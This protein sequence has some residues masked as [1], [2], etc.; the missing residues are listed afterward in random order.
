MSSAKRISVEEVIQQVEDEDF[1][2]LFEGS[3]EDFGLPSDEEESNEQG[4]SMSC[5]DIVSESCTQH[6]D[7]SSCDELRLWTSVPSQVQEHPFT[8]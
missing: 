1:D 3:D 6:R 4:S 2:F 5:T 7:G 8:V